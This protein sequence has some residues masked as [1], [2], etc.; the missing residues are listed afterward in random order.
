MNTSIRRALP[1]LIVLLLPATLLLGGCSL[2][3]HRRPDP[4]APYKKLTPGVTYEIT[5]DNPGML[6]LDLR[7]AQEYNGETG[8]IRGAKN[9]PLARLPYRLLEISSF[10]DETVVV[11][12]GAGD[13]G[14]QGMAILLSSGFDNAILMDGGIEKWIHEGF[15]TVL[16]AN[17]AARRGVEK[18]RPVM[19]AKPGTD[20]P[21][22]KEEVT[23]EPTPPPPPPPPAT[24]H[25][26]GRFL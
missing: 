26:S 20:K 25:T 19:P 8:H 13:C 18:G 15:K 1:L 16:P 11:Y 14:D 5:R 21:D 3:R 23:V 10:R 22:P 17:L 4:K 2:F 9:I 6:I 7:P 12:C 24:N